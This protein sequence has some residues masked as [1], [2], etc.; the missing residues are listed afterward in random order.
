[1]SVEWTQ[2]F[3]FEIAADWQPPS[4]VCEM[5][6]VSP[7]QWA[8]I[9]EDP[10]FIKTVE[11]HFRVVHK[12]GGL[13]VRQKAAMALEHGI[14]VLHRIVQNDQSP[15]SSISGA[16]AMLE[17]LAGISDA[18]KPVGT[19]LQPNIF[20][21]QDDRQEEYVSDESAKALPIN[22]KYTENR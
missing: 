21:G 1:M 22:V 11:R 4:Q 3:A 17:R 13:S 19:A 7:D 8:V 9:R 6:S 5:H 15:P 16:M 10:A 14:P 20:L 18:T 12:A 2:N